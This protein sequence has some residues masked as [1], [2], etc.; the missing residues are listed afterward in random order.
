MAILTVVVGCGGG[1]SAPGVGA[2]SNFELRM[3]DS[4]VSAGSV[5]ASAGQQGIPEEATALRVYISEIRAIPAGDGEPVL[6]ST[7]EQVIDLT[8]L[9]NQTFT[10]VEADLPPGDYSHIG[11]IVSKAEIELPGS[12]EPVEV[13]VPSGPQTGMKLKYD[14]HIVDGENTVLTLDWNTGNSVHCTGNGKWILRSTALIVIAT[15]QVPTNDT[16]TVTVVDISPAEVGPGDADVGMLKLEFEIDDNFADIDTLS[17]TL[18]GTDPVSDVSDVSVYLDGGAPPDGSLDPLG[19]DVELAAAAVG[20]TSVLLD[21][22]DQTVNYDGD[23]LDTDPDLVLFIAC[24][25]ASGA[26][27]GNTVGVSI[28]PANDIVSADSN[29]DSVPDDTIAGDPGSADASIVAPTP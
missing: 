6:V 16:V 9:E 7:A 8:D 21:I 1:G 14:F 22:P 4:S 25:I 28:D 19:D 15:E 27:D 18:T 23:D 10:L 13:K 2:S 12:V 17:V 11:L 29:G 20:G 5:Q 24:D 26:S 3:T